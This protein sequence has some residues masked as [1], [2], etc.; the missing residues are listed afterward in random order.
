M[1]A[2]GEFGED[3]AEQERVARALAERGIMSLSCVYADDDPECHGEPLHEFSW[4]S[5]QGCGSTLGGERYM[6]TAWIE[7]ES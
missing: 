3:E 2:N 7:P 1:D 5:C 4:R 6:V